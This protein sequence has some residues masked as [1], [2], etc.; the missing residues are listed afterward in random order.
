M[1][2][3]NLLKNLKKIVKILIE[4]GQDEGIKA[5]QETPLGKSY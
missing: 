5:I 3:D 1:G 2:L 4:K